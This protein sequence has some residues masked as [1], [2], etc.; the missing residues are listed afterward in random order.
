MH[1]MLRLGGQ[2]SYYN[3]V[4]GAAGR[5]WPAGRRFPTSVLFARF[6][7]MR[8]FR[9]FSLF[10]KMKTKRSGQQ[11]LVAQYK[12]LVPHSTSVFIIGGGTVGGAWV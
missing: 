3:L 2:Y 8:P 5:I 4:K 12:H 11:T 1:N 10:I 6:L 9:K 7:K